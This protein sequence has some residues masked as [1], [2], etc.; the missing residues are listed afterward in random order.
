[1]NYGK[2]RINITYISFFILLITA[3]CVLI[4]CTLDKK[5]LNPNTSPFVWA[6]VAD[7]LSFI[8]DRIDIPN[9]WRAEYLIMN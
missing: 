7:F 5:G 4:M 6:L 8:M 2:I 9:S 1:M 3:N